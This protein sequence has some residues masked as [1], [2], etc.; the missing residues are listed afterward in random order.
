MWSR[1]GVV[2]LY[3]ADEHALSV[4]AASQEPICA[5][6]RSPCVLLSPHRM[7]HMNTNDASVESHIIEVG[8]H[9][10]R[11]LLPLDQLGR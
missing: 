10:M 4:A 3:G 5:I 9:T 6:D 7:V 11:P 8:A 2:P 1:L